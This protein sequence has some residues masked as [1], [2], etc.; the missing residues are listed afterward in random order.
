MH[1]AHPKHRVLGWGGIAAVFEAWLPSSGASG[2]QRIPEEMHVHTT[3]P[4]F[5][6][7]YPSSWPHMRSGKAVPAEASCCVVLFLFF[8]CSRET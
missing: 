4:G 8:S 3:A 5:H 1:R 6:P 2:T 7:F